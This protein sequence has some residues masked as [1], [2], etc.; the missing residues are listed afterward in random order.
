MD[1]EGGGGGT[2]HPYHTRFRGRRRI[3]PM[4]IGGPAG[5]SL[6]QRSELAGSGTAFVVPGILG[7]QE[8]VEQ[9]GNPRDSGGHNLS[10]CSSNRVQ[11]PQGTREPTVRGSRDL[12]RDPS[13]QSQTTEE[14][15]RTRTPVQSSRS[16]TVPQ[17]QESDDDSDGSGSGADLKQIVGLFTG[18][19]KE[20]KT[21]AQSV[22]RDVSTLRGHQQEST[23]SFTQCAQAI[24]QDVALLRDH[25]DATAKQQDDA[26]SQLLSQNKETSR[27]E[28][29]VRPPGILPYSVY[30]KGNPAE[31]ARFQAVNSNT[32]NSY[33]MSSARNRHSESLHNFNDNAR[34]NRSEVTPV[35]SPERHWYEEEED[36]S[37]RPNHTGDRHQ[38]R[39]S[40]RDEFLEN[41]K[42]AFS[43]FCSA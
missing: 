18:V 3:D 2:P 43:E 35:Q 21:F 5:H 29:A 33:S 27:Q 12:S 14:C 40:R 23:K 42:G 25:Y 22:A 9:P 15:P 6:D 4:D 8:S 17:L 20:M 30:E 37:L 19:I 7:T 41:K 38:E 24:A 36:G 34:R 16:T 28:S 26:L 1:S 31:S 32:G 11:G 13:A 10:T 39:A